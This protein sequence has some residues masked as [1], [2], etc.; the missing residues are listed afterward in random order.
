MTGKLYVV[1]TPIGNLSDLSP[2][3]VQTL[4]EVDFI[5]AEDTRVTLK[6]LNHFEIKKP[7]VS[8]FEHNKYERGD[9]ICDRIEAGETCALVTDAG[10]PAISDPGELLVKQCAQRGI[11]VLA[12]PGP[13]AVITALAV[14]GLP[15]GRF[16]FEGFLS[17]NK[18][19]RR[20][21]LEAVR[22]ERRTMV[23]YEAPHKL[24]D[25]LA[26]ML[27][28]WGDRKIA[29][30]REL[31]KV[32]EEVIRTTLAEAAARYAD[33]GAKGEFVLVIEG[34][35]APEKTEYSLEE[36]VE[37]ARGF[38]RDGLSA[39]EAAKRA[40]AE[41]R[42]KKGEIYRALQSEALASDEN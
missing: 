29:L 26:D 32:H 37:L 9:I 34:A 28:A 38:A 30:V 13:S 11:P 22:E 10:M 15:T 14:S 35:S 6:L 24:A 2:R 41:T 42:L 39:S 36:A 40:A 8:Y 21:H 1:G 3:A 7:M 17:V 18:K 25:T 23:F 19:S 4:R 20:E 12:V 5:A 27:A 33:G 16:T 31:T